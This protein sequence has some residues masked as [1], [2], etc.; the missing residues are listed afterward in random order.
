MVIGQFSAA[1]W[2]AM[3]VELNHG[4]SNYIDDRALCAALRFISVCKC[5][6]LADPTQL[7]RVGDGYEDNKKSVFTFSTETERK[8]FP[9]LV[10]LRSFCLN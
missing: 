9:S 10:F 2:Q 1:R 3:P 5:V 4:L 6:N 8:K 7:L